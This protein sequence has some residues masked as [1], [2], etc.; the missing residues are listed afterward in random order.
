MVNAFWLDRELEQAVVW[1]VDRHVLS[2]VLECSLV[3]ST[4]ALRNGWEGENLPMS[5]E[6]HPLTRWAGDAYDNWAMLREYT[7]LAHEEWRYRWD[8]DP[9]EV[10]GSWAT[11]RDI[12]PEAVAELAWD[13][14]SGSD[15]PQ[16]TDGWHAD[17]YVDA[18][19]YY[20][21]NEKHHLFEWAKERGPPPWLDDYTVDEE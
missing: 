8:H 3:L 17:D 20:Y 12:D 13:E 1:L 9:E 2:S 18:Y 4:A 14:P 15:P 10:H 11:V 21:A 7:R 6:H 5:H 16:V 19:R